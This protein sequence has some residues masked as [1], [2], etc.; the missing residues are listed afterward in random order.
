MLLAPDKDQKWV[1]LDVPY[2]EF[3]NA[4]G[5][6]DYSS[7][8]YYLEQMRLEDVGHLR[9]KYALCITYYNF[10]NG[11][12]WRNFQTSS[13]SFKEWLWKTTLSFEMSPY[14]E[15]SKTMFRHWFDF[16]NLINVFNQCIS[17]LVIICSLHRVY[18]CVCTYTAILFL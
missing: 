1:F 9:R 14:A 13:C 2:A 7:N 5:L 15:K 11:S 17:C 10:Y 8:Y 18:L 12:L 6:E 16:L 4:K 3:P